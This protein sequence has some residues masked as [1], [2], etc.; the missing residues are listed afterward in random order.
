MK[1]ILALVVFGAIVYISFQD[2]RRSVKAVFFILVIDGALRKWVLPQAS[3]GLYF[4]KD[5]V[6]LGA[7]LRYYI[8]PTKEPHFPIRNNIINLLIWLASGWCIFQ[9]FNPKLGSP[10]VGILG[11]KAY[12]FYIPLVWMLPSLFRNQDEFYQFL[13][14]HLLLLI[15]VG[16]LGIVQFFSPIHSVINQYAPDTPVKIETFGFAGSTNVRIT[17]TFSYINSYQ[18]YLTACFALILPFLAIKQSK[19]WQIITYVELFLVFLNSFMTGSRTPVIAEIL[20]LIGFLFFRTLRNPEKTLV[21][22]SR[23]LPFVAVGISTAL[24]I[25]RPIIEAFNRRVSSNT[26]IG[27]R[28]GLSIISPFDLTQYT[29]FD[30][31]GVGATHAGTVA[32]RNILGLPAGAYIPIELEPEMGKVALE[33]GPIGFIFWYTMRVALIIALFMT[34][35]K[36]KRTFL[37]DF[38]LAA[39]LMQAILFISQMVFHHTFAVYYWLFSGFIFLLPWLEY[40][41]DWREQQQQNWQEN[42]PDSS[43]R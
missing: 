2:W 21:W 29:A 15:P 39:C 20:C 18:G 14:S 35:W 42:Y 38:A 32:L 11:L 30:G 9:A 1:L 28:V 12:L 10:L 3:A 33:I 7:Y 16:I 26:D 19:E 23:L 27:E 22:I 24:I 25:F 17:G 40:V 43:Y 37:S 36:L 34:F 41:E 13:R 8:F 5:I 31:Y 4:L 6:L